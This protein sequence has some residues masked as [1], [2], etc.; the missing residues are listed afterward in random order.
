MSHFP[1]TPPKGV[2]FLKT[3]EYRGP[4]YS[5]TTH[6]VPLSKAHREYIRVFW[7]ENVPRR[8]LNVVGG[9]V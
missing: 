9:T 3:N 4:E 2:Y 6:F 8:L 5:D 7:E 1:T